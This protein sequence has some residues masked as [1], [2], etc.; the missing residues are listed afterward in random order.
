M[1]AIGSIELRSAISGIWLLLSFC[2]ILTA[3]IPAL[4]SIS[5]HG[6]RQI[7]T[8]LS[9]SSSF[10]TNIHTYLQVP[11]RYFWHMY[12]LGLFSTA[13]IVAASPNKYY[14]I[15]PNHSFIITLWTIHLTRRLLECH[16]ITIYNE[17]TM[18]VAGYVVGLLHYVLAP[19]TILTGIPYTSFTTVTCAIFLY[20]FASGVQYYAHLT[21]YHIKS[22]RP[23][24]RPYRLPKSLP[25]RYSATPH[26]FAEILLYISF[27]LLV[28]DFSCMCLLVW[29][30]VNLAVVANQQ[31]HWYISKFPEEVP[32]RWSRL[33]PVVW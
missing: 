14:R 27:L 15:S 33:V 11:K 20:I 3:C 24:K 16:F 10:M 25:F 4:H 9:S 26:Y 30:T 17:S 32:L 7:K 8:I 6:K 31:Y 12:L 22:N 23:A 2:A 29:V 1:H 18:H 28:P 21:L 5:T 13:T 19:F